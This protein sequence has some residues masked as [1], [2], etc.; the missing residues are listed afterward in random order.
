[1]H[2]CLEDAFGN[3]SFARSCE[4][5]VP[6]S[7]SDRDIKTNADIEC[8]PSHDTLET[9]SS[10]MLGPK[11]EQLLAAEGEGQEEA[12]S[13][14]S[15]CVVSS[16]SKTITGTEF[17][18]CS[19]DSLICHLRRKMADFSAERDGEGSFSGSTACHPTSCGGS[20][21]QEA[22]MPLKAYAMQV[23]SCQDASSL[24]VPL[25]DLLNPFPMQSGGYLHNLRDEII[26]LISDDMEDF[27]NTTNWTFR[28]RGI[29]KSRDDGGGV[30]ETPFFDPLLLLDG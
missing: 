9:G 23:A 11:A 20:H 1:M 27:N 5:P 29:A 17:E 19:P 8:K 21:S 3:H 15:P 22:A 25:E 16:T 7:S 28:S 30:S 10:N 4:P 14:C 18:Q 6:T 13:H 24:E 2:P 26:S 12:S